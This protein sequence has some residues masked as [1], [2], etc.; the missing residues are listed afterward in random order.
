M[1]LIAGERNPKVL[2]QMARSRMRTEIGQLEEAF[3]GQDKSHG[4][5]SIGWAALLP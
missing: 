5:R 3:N 1:P 2:A 4:G